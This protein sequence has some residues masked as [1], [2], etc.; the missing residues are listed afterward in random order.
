MKHVQVVVIVGI[1]F[2]SERDVRV[3]FID[4]KVLQIEHV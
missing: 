1:S 4:E 3:D 2:T